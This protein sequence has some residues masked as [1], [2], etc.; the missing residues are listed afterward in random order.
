VG[1]ERDEECSEVSTGELSLK[2][3]GGGFPVL[4]KIQEAFGDAIEMGKVIACKNLPLDDGELDIDLVEPTGM[5]RG[6]HQC[7][8][9]VEMVKAL[10]GPAATIR[11]VIIHDPEDAAGLVIRWSGHHLLDEPVKRGDTILG[12]TAAKDA[13]PVDDQGGDIGPATAARG[14]VLDVHGS[15]RPTTLGGVL[16]AVSLNAGLFIGGDHERVIFQRPVG[17]PREPARARL[18]RRSRDHEGRSNRGDTT[19][20]GSLH[21]ADATA[22][23]R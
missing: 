16:A 17:G 2:G 20:G 4:S 3:A 7:Q 11:R 1:S 23:Y 8:A 15:A 13:G 18:W 9:G 5:I 12:F 6:L 21:A 14:L 19:V 22:R 10:D